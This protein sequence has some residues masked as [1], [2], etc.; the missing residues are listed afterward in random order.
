[1]I[2]YLLGICLVGQCWAGAEEAVTATNLDEKNFKDLV[3]VI[4]IKDACL[5][6]TF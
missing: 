6:C 5:S 4:M 1:M 2:L 3:S